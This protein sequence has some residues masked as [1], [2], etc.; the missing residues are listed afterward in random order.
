MKGFPGGSDGREAACN[1]GDP[2]LIP[3]SGGS[4]EKEVATHSSI[5]AWR[6]PWTEE[7][8]GLHPM[9]LQRV[10]HDGATN[11]HALHLSGPLFPCLWNGGVL[12]WYCLL[13]CD[14]VSAQ[15]YLSGVSPTTC[16]FTTRAILGTALQMGEGSCS[17]I[18]C[19]Q[20]PPYQTILGKLQAAFGGRKELSFATHCLCSPGRPCSH[21][22]SG[23]FVTHPS[24][25]KMRRLATWSSSELTIRA[26]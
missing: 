7:P 8:G 13:S 24:V 9:G 6:I 11:T 25:C 18:L 12:K 1:A 22:A 10:R 15:W 21:W 4:L 2:G 23:A 3:G 14:S 17:L 20:P 5:L 26:H 19:S 16:H